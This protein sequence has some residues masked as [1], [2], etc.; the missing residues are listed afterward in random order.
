M[1]RRWIRR[2]GAGFGIALVTA[3][4]ASAFATVAVARALQPS[5]G[6]GD[7][8]PFL[9]ATI[10]QIAANDYAEAW[11]TLEPT[12]QGLVPRDRYVRCESASPIPGVLSSLRVLGIRKEQI[13]V[14][15][16][17]GRSP[18]RAV[19][20]RIVISEPALHE[21]VKIVDTVHAVEVDGRWAWILPA[22]RLALDSS[23]TCGAPVIPR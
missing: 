4:A 22:K 9:R 8:V 6:L 18:A 7:P 14:A 20:F 23:A 12:Q 13:Q 5:T 2:W 11:N 19:T 17:S 16:T 10:A 21:S 1:A 15:G 3:A